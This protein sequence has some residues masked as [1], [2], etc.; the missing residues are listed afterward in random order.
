VL[1]K[2]YKSKQ[3]SP[4]FRQRIARHDFHSVEIF[5]TDLAAIES[6]I[7]YDKPIYIGV[8]VLELS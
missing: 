6:K 8:V 2:Q 7:M 4:G 1:V 5:G 3:N